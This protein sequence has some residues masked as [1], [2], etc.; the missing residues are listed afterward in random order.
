MAQQKI[1]LDWQNVDTNKL[2]EDLQ[3]AWQSIATA[4]HAFEAAFVA[5]AKAANKLPEG[6]SFAFA[7]RRGLGVAVVDESSRNKPSKVFTF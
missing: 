1:E 3:A 2:P 7:Y 5:A 4:R 6:K